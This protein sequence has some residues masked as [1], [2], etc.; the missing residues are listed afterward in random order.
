[1]RT[2]PNII[3]RAEQSPSPENTTNLGGLLTS[4]S[5]ESDLLMLAAS[6]SRSPFAPVAFALS[7]PARSTKQILLVLELARQE[8]AMCTVAKRP[9][10]ED[11]ED[12]PCSE[13][14]DINLKTGIFVVYEM[15]RFGICIYST[16]TKVGHAI[17]IP[18]ACVPDEAIFNSPLRPHT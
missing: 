4:P 17:G 2:R 12:F 16:L 10:R 1:M 18:F 5:V 6:R 15:A 11:G 8:T 9:T 3:G 14:A 7:D 13:C